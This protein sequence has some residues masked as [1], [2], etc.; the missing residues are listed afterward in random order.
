MHELC[1]VDAR[2]YLILCVCF[3]LYMIIYTMEA[4]AVFFFLYFLIFSSDEYSIF[5]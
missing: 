3:Y 4:S 2:F 1:W 5:V